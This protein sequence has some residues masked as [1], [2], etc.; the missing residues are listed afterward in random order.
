MNSLIKLTISFYAIKELILI[1]CKDMKYKTHL[2]LENL[3]F[4]YGLYLKTYNGIFD[5]RIKNKRNEIKIIKIYFNN[6]S[7]YRV[8][9]WPGKDV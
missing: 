5:V 6:I 4:C 3:L 8:W 1:T 9:V 7:Y 2:L